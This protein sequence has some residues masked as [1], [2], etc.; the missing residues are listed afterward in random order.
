MG[1]RSTL[2]TSRGGV[3]ADEQMGQVLTPVLIGKSGRSEEQM[4]AES[5]DNRIMRRMRIGGLFGLLVLCT[6]ATSSSVSA[7]P[8][9]APRPTNAVLLSGAVADEVGS[10]DVPQFAQGP[11]K[12]FKASFEVIAQPG[13]GFSLMF[14][15][16]VQYP[17]GKAL[18]A[19]PDVAEPNVVGSLCIGFDTSNPPPDT[20]EV[21]SIAR[22]G[23]NVYDRPQREI[24]VHSEGVEKF[25]RRAPDFAT[26]QR[27][28]IEVSVEYVPGGA[29]LT[30]S[31]NGE[32]VYDRALV[33]GAT[34]FEP[35]AAIVSKGTANRPRLELDKLS[36]TVGERMT[37]PFAEPVSVTLFDST[38]V[39]G[40]Q[41]DPV[42]L[43]DFS[44]VPAQTARVIATLMLDAPP[45]GIDPWDR[46]GAA[47]L[48]TPDRQRF[49][50]IRF[51]TPYA[52]PY[53]WTADVTDLLP[54]FRDQQS[55]GL[56]IDTWQKG[57]VASLKLD[58]YPGTPARKPAMVRNLWQGEP[59]LGDPRFP[60]ANFFDEKTV[61]VPQGATGAKLRLTVTGHGQAPNSK[62]AAEFL[63]LKRTV[64][65]NG[66]SFTNTL[67]KTDNYL[68][69][70]R[71]Q[72]GTWPFDRAGWAPG[73]IVEPWEI[74]VS[75]LIAGGAKELTISYEL[76][77]YV[78][79][80]RGQT[81]PPMHW[82]DSQIVFYAK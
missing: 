18:P 72:A 33:T 15:D 25:N 22:S 78:N 58:F 60:V 66:K 77:D 62:N 20:G 8:D 64:K 50:I 21:K 40:A 4:R 29:E 71:P 75:E 80:A 10:Y 16:A 6:A 45:D 74:D 69:P 34:A 9:T 3:V 73:S 24:S 11:A 70:C 82:V 44:V 12:S 31:V 43:V 5:V 65:V 76:E 19:L 39:T 35:R 38:R 79:D 28:P 47:Y 42:G 17:Y 81:D 53:I 54:L 2:K 56:F 26:G 7:A 68:N 59:I 46:R 41:R 13:E 14:V 1:V 36:F 63:P 57:F 52:K 61:I 49:E 37:R 51:M 30:L 55:V 48:V 23:G 67:W 27:V 32:K